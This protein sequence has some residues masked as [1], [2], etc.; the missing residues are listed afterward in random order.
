MILPPTSVISHHH[1]DVTNITVNAIDYSVIFFWISGI[2][3][4]SLLYYHPVFNLE[5]FNCPLPKELHYISSKN[6]T[7]ISAV[8]Y[9][10]AICFD[11]DGS[12][13]CTCKRGYED[14]DPNGVTSGTVEG[15]TECVESNECLAGTAICPTNSFCQNTDA[16]YECK[17]N[18][19]GP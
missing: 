5:R 14:A 1:Y 13:F 16:S 10:N 15:S 8:H 3:I 18:A 7:V 4:L 9:Y 11:N 19:Y 2:G 17:K 6:E 12:F